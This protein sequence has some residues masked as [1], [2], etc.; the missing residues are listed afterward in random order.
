MDNLHKDFV[1]DKKYSRKNKPRYEYIQKKLENSLK[2]IEL[3]KSR[4]VELRLEIAFL[5]KRI[6]GYKVKLG[7]KE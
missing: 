5:E 6:E 7:I 2:K 4:L 1:I 3:K